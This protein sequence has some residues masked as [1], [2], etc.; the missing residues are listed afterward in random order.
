MLTGSLLF[1]R[2]VMANPFHN[3]YVCMP[4]V[5][6][7]QAFLDFT[8]R[9]GGPCEEGEKWMR[10]ISREDGVTLLLP[11]DA[12]LSKDVQ[13]DLERFKEFYGITR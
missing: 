1:S 12:P 10:V 6:A 4:Q 9:D 8:I 11:S 5:A 13:R 2:E 7:N 3:L